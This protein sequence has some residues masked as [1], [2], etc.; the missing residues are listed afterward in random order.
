LQEY[1]FTKQGENDGSFSCKLYRTGEG[2]WYDIEEASMN[3][4]KGILWMFKSA[5]DDKA[6]KDV[7]K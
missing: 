1:S 7:V 2:N 3:T 5:I 4:E 6:K